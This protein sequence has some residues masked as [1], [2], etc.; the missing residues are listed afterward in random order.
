ML[1]TGA[2]EEAQKNLE[3]WDPTLLSNRAIGAPELIAHLQGQ[4]TLD[5]ARGPHNCHTTICET[6]THMVSIQDEGLA[7]LSPSGCDKID[8]KKAIWSVTATQMSQ[9]DMC[10]VAFVTKFS[11][12]CH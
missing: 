4:L 6:P 1:D 8:K 7:A 2:L 3:N 9:F 12:R 11:R 10:T 5:E